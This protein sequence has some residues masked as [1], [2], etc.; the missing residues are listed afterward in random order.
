M[1]ACTTGQG[2]KVAPPEHI[3]R[4]TTHSVHT[5]I[6]SDTLAALQSPGGH[7]PRVARGG[8]VYSEACAG[9]CG[10]AQTPQRQIYEHSESSMLSFAFFQRLE[11]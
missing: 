7:Q 1:C 2:G 11:Q 3:A 6:Y 9:T 5:R 10:V 4:G 8:H